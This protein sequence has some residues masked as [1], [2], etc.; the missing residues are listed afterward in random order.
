MI[1]KFPVKKMIVRQMGWLKGNELETIDAEL[2][3]VDASIAALQGRRR[4]LLAEYRSILERIAALV[5][6]FLWIQEGAFEH[7]IHDPYDAA[8]FC[9]VEDF[10]SESTICSST[11]F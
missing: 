10:V 3:K 7:A 4:I 2:R 8:P 1:I 9:V 11:F 6:L 5:F